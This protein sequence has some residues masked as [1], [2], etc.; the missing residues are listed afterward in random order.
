MLCRRQY[1]LNQAGKA[2][3]LRTGRA[4][5]QRKIFSN[6][7]S[8]SGCFQLSIQNIF[9]RKYLFVGSNTKS[10]REYLFMEINEKR[11]IRA[12]RGKCLDCCGG[13]A[14]EVELCTVPKCPLF[15]YRNLNYRHEPDQGQQHSRAKS[16]ESVPAAEQDMQYTLPL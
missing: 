16:E 1:C 13:Q 2:M 8:H 7:S 9:C 14:K 12:I 10:G 5:I 11:L 3:L 4:G 15:S 6:S